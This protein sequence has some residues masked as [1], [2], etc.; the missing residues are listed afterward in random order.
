MTETSL[1]EAIYEGPLDLDHPWVA[2]LD[3][4]RVAM[5]SQSAQLMFA[6]PEAGAPRG[7]I[8]ALEHDFSDARRA[9]YSGFEAQNPIRYDRLP[10][11][12]ITTFADFISR[13]DFERSRFYRQ[14]GRRHGVEYGLSLNIGTIDGLGV[15]LNTAKGGQRDFS[16]G[17]RTLTMRLLPH[18]RRVLRLSPGFGQRHLRESA[19]SVAASW[20]IGAMI[21]NGNGRII[22][23]DALMQAII[24]AH[25]CT[26]RKAE[27][28]HFHERATRSRFLNHL[29]ALAGAAPGSA[30]A[31]SC[32][33]EDRLELL[34][35]PAGGASAQYWIHA[36]SGPARPISNELLCGLFD[37][38]PGESDVALL[39][40][41]GWDIA[42]IAAGRGIT[43]QSVRTY[44]KRIFA[45]TGVK[46][47]AELV[48]L[49]LNS[50]VAV[51]SRSPYSG[52]F[53]R[54]IS[55]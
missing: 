7:S 21:V 54:N 52:T 40:S 2:F 34:I 32:G 16:A 19:P 55:R 48:A 14:F 33:C 3:E 39:L 13:A 49:V 41:Q 18:L 51:K 15:W 35:Q 4:Y 26:S 37:L 9:Y 28:L 5:C 44:C 12:G 23:A 20:G 11:G 8:D 29:V 24:D 38:S 47:Q 42:M 45:K 36:K 31:L 25:P 46:R 53:G 22:E 30:R 10:A 50:V 6:R 17:E 1:I 27:N 43:E